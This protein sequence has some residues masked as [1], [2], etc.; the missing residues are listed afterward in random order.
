MTYELLIVAL[1]LFLGGAVQSIGGFGSMLVAMPMITLVLPLHLT[2]PLLA[3]LG[4]PITL[5][6]FYHNRS[7]IDWAE[8][9]RIVA[10]SLAGIPLGIW[11]LATLDSALIMRVLG[12]LL[13][14]YSLYALVLEPRLLA[15]RHAARASSLWRSLFVGLTSGMLGGA[16]N[17][18]GPPLIVYGDWLR[19]PKARFKAL[20]QGVF[21]V[22]GS[23]ILIGHAVAGHLGTH[24]LPYAAV[25]LPGILL[26]LW[27]G[28]RIDRHIPPHQ[29]RATVL[30]LLFLMGLSMV[31]R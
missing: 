18:N 13:I 29:F 31:G 15:Q 17:T 5:Y 4:L 28:H 22:N 3:T 14:A 1:A 25:A 6:I 12:V 24:M 30:A 26:G 27:T 10:G 21:L 11:A 7:G 9:F 8:T 2:A 16:F 23:L 19:W 20:L